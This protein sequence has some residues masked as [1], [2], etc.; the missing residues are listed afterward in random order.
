VTTPASVKPAAVLFDRDGTLV[1]DVPYNGD[2]RLVRPVPGAR[3]A[4]ELLRSENVATGIVTN[5]SGIGRGLLTV[6][7]VHRVHAR[8]EQLLGP[9]DDW[10]FC[11]HL[12]ESGCACRK[13][14]PGMVLDAC[15]AL[16]VR[17]EAC[18][19]IGDIA[20]DLDAATA[21]GALAVMVPTPATRRA[22][23]AAAPLVATDLRAAT[24]LAVDLL[25][26]VRA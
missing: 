20:A 7:D 25:V 6:R 1:E 9:F 22:E 4:L 17:P 8:M 21:A 18:V 26:G 11:P 15:A 24:E 5:Q 3:E 13:P 16:G 2:P 14:A 12:P 19:V 23:I 10:R